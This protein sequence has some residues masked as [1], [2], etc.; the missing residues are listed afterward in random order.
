VLLVVEVEIGL[1][2]DQDALDADL[3]RVGKALIEPMQ[4]GPF[5]RDLFIPLTPDLGVAADDDSAARGVGFQVGVVVVRTLD[6]Q[7]DVDHG[8]VIPADVFRVQRILAALTRLAL[9]G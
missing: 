7:A 5:T 9:E 6:A 3:L 4:V 2:V 1:P 8:P